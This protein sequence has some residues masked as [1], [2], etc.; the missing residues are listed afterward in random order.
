M[1]QEMVSSL[2][3]FLV[4]F[5]LNHGHLLGFA[6]FTVFPTCDLEELVDLFLIFTFSRNELLLT[7]ILLSF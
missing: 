3:F 2:I 6:S 5:S 7:F 1:P 4:C